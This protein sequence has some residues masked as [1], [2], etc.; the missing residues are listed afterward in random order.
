MSRL[1]M[2]CALELS[3]G[4]AVPPALAQSYPIA[5]GRRLVREAG[6]TAQ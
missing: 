3:L 6:L 2:K 1:L 4:L 5:K